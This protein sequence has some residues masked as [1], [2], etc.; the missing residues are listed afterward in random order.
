MSPIVST[1]EIDRPPEEVFAY[2]TDPTRF[3]EW[4]HG[5]SHRRAA[6]RRRPVA[7]HLRP[8]LPRARA[9]RPAHARHPAD[10][11]QAGAAELPAPEGAAGAGR[12]TGRG[13]PATRR[14]AGGLRG[15]SRSRGP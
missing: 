2:A 5:D 13:S 9:E 4:Q 11:R 1:I 12:L 6:Q 7:G 14:M 8:R 15:S 3:A 10:G